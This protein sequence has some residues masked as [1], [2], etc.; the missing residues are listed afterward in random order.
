MT[1]MILFMGGA[2]VLCQLRPQLIEQSRPAC[3][4]LHLPT[5]RLE[6]SF[7]WAPLSSPALLHSRKKKKKKP[8]ES[9]TT[10][11]FWSEVLVRRS[12]M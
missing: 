5:A 9:A 3:F 8:E 6:Y 11:S 4:A 10:R 12:V 2:T 1:D 7:L